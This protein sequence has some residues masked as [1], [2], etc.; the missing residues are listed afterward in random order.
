MLVVHGS[1]SDGSLCLWGEDPHRPV[2]SASQALRSAR[3]HPFAIPADRLGEIYIGKHGSADLQ[4]PSLRSSPL[5][6]PEL[7]RV[8]PRPPAHSRPA[9]LPW[10]VPVV[11][12]PSADA[13]TILDDP[14]AGVRYGTSAAYFLVDIA[15][16]ARM[17]LSRGR[18]VPAL[19]YADG[20]PVAFWRPVVQG[21]DVM[22]LNALTTA[23]PPVCRAAVG[24]PGAYEIVTAALTGFVDVLA[25]AVMPPADLLLPPRRGRRLKRLPAAEAWLTALTTP[26][27]GFE[28]DPD[29]LDTLSEALAPWDQ[30]GIEDPGPAR[31]VFRVSDG[32]DDKADWRLEFLLRSVA[33][34]SL[35]VSAEQAWDDDG[36]LSRWLDRPEELLL[37][38][39]GRAVRIFPEL[40]AGLRTARP[41]GIDLDIDGAYHF[42]SAVAPLLD[43]AGFE[44]L[45]PSWWDPRRRLGLAVSASTPVDGVVETASR[46]GREQLIDFRWELAVGDDTLTEDE[47]NALSQ[48][49]APLIRLRGQWVSVDPEQ[50]RRGLEFLE[51]N[52]TGQAGTGE[53]LALAAG[54]SVDAPL[55]ITAVRADGWLGDLLN[56]VAAQSLQPLH[57]PPGFRATLRPYQQ[58]GLS[59]LAF[60]SSLGL[61]SCL[62][63]DMGLGKTVQLLAL[64]ATQR[65]DHPDTAS[66][67]LICPMSL[68]GNW[69]REAAKFAPALRVYAHHGT[70]RLHGDE[71]SEQLEATDLI[72]TTYATAARDIDE[73]ADY[74]WNRVV[75][76]EAQAVKN[77][78]SRGA[79]AVRR[80]HAE[81]RVA[82][83]GTPVENR[84]A[85]LW[86]VMDF[87][88]PGL[89][90]SPEVFKARYAVPV[91][92]Y[93]QTEPAE[94]LRRITRPY[95]LRRLKTDPNIIDDLP[96]KIETKQ[97]C[98]LTVEQGS[99]YR[100]IVD[101]MMEKIENTDGIARRGNVLAAMTKLKQV[102]NHPAQL[103][104]DRSVIGAR[105]G[106]VTRLEEILEEILAEGDRVLCFTQFTEFAEMLAPHL[107]ARFGQDVAYLHGRTPK[108]RRD[109]MVA[110]FQA[111]E[112][113]SIFLLSLK[114]GGTGLT[115]TAANHV[116]HL[117]RWWNPAVENQA[118][119]RA[120]RIG[121]KKSVQVSKFIC[122]G[123]LEERIDDMIEQKRA[124]AD[125]VVGDG[126][127]WLTELSTGDLRKLFTLSEGA[128]GE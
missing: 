106:K 54:Q 114:A 22:E 9:L 100:S 34:P 77:S 96:E 23:M 82:L 72:V 61:G 21:A 93:G 18:I 110:R 71:L 92:K 24:A 40:A 63:D 20:V 55:E 120:F 48:T 112:G 103:L 28:A 46:F 116:V 78:L 38:E 49:K 123:T 13:L 126:E 26:D 31:A 84:L 109:E 91:E 37:A 3:P 43:D 69:Q 81:H 87:L 1:W 51:A 90:G 65:H 2:K 57:P 111:G 30:I 60:L 105:S 79:K 102:C 45:L 66:T 122:T 36:M 74:Q 125:L 124:L 97:Y 119:D 108:K 14:A 4:L 8:T 76:D 6:S 89:L 17:L 62:A 39:L 68:V 32:D 42:L 70:A 44:V 113:P 16:F 99:L 25:R 53:I 15:N 7:L 85:E 118:T 73:L 67:L 33:D 35:L 83:T 117:D 127:G 27:G 104:H 10:T 86:A 59:W 88:N 29:E 95:I 19:E 5:D 11:A 98:R 94:R 12:V 50:L 64:E 107:A 115:L 52:P 58:R 121:Q 75:L 101:E 80:F 128:I 47:I 56:G 41:C